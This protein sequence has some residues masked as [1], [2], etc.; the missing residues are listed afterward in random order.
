LPARGRCHSWTEARARIWDPI[1]LF[2]TPEAITALWAQYCKDHP[3][4][5]ESPSEIGSLTG[6][7]LEARTKLGLPLNDATAA[8]A[9]V[10]SDATPGAMTSDGINAMTVI[11]CWGA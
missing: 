5:K 4:V 8:Y 10:S 1:L 6:K 11:L 7:L 2:A 3:T 9:A